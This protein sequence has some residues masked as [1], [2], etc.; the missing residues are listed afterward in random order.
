MSPKCELCDGDDSRSHR[1]LEC[2]ALQDVR[3]RHPDAVHILSAVRY[4]WNYIP[5]ANSHPDQLL[6]KAF[7]STIRDCSE[8]APVSVAN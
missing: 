7:V 8:L 4:D 2:S 6:Q 1:T 5:L 3:S